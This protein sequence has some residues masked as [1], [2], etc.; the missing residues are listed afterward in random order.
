MFVDDLIRQPGLWSGDDPESGIVIS[1]RIRLARNVKG[2][3]FPGWAK[4]DERLRLAETVR[5]V[6]SKVQT[7]KKVI[8]LDTGELSQVDRDVLKE[9]HLISHEL[10]LSV[11]GSSVALLRNER[12]AIMVNEEDHLRMQ[13][14]SPGLELA[15]L[16]R[17]MDALDSQLEQELPYAFS[18][19]LGYLSACPSNVGTGLRASVM[20]HLSGLRLLNE[21]E[22]VI[23]GLDKIGLAVRGQLGEGSEAQG[24]VFQ[25]SNQTTLGE[26]EQDI[27]DR[28]IQV[29][30]ELEQHECNARGRLMEDRAAFVRDHVGR[31]LGILSNAHLLSSREV[32]DL[33]A[34]LRLGVELAMVEHVTPAELHEIMLL[35]QPG[36]LQKIYNR[37][38]GPEARDELRAQLVRQRIANVTMVD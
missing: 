12:I 11:S 19:R 16:W 33:L 36:H 10:S 30:T 3:A 20:M 31:A 26:T 29:A 27:V 7:L 38:I 9:R 37:E 24:N 6:L 17:R 4:D 34:A 25:I 23:K 32:I 15:D 22:P 1:S 28:L 5:Q 14:I 35:T 18:P 2:F 13:A 21:I 8:I